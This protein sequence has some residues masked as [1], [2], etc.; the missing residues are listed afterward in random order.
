MQTI[1]FLHGIGRHNANWHE[2][3]A[4]TLKKSRA[5]LKAP[6]DFDALYKPVGLL[7]DDLLQEYWSEHA[8]RAEAL[9]S[10]PLP[11]DASPLIRRVVEFAQ[12]NPTDEH[13]WI[14]QWGDAVLYLTTELGQRI[15][16]RVWHAIITELDATSTPPFSIIAHSLGT[17]VIHDVLQRAYTDPAVEN[18]D[19]F[20]KAKVLTQ[21]ANVTRAT[22]F[23]EG[24][25]T[26]EDMVVHPSHNS[27]E[28]VTDRFI[29]VSHPLDPIAVFRRFRAQR[30]TSFLGQLDFS[31]IECRPEDIV[32]IEEVHELTRYLA[33]PEVA[34]AI[35]NGTDIDVLGDQDSIS[36]D[37]VSVARESYEETTVIG[38]W[39]AKFNRVKD[40]E[41]ESPE[42]WEHLLKLLEDKDDDG[43]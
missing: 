30:Y 1:F 9:A 5:A 32:K 15:Q 23:D 24:H 41:F 34:A 33:I 22:S 20:G 8:T 19:L 3:A 16:D 35:F 21:V 42:D 28:G 29:N 6:G 17:R 36:A 39:E 26:S 4:N 10:I 25:L 14:A 40:L 11:M 12:T 37:Q 7:Y 18:R 13:P 43:E 27:S 31:E 2:S 38:E